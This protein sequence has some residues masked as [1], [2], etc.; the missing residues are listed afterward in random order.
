MITPAESRTLPLQSMS[1]MNLPSYTRL[2]SGVRH[3]D[4]RHN[5]C[6]HFQMN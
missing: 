3:L 6:E 4:P 5:L 2:H 1:N